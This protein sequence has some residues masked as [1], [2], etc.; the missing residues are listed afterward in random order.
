MSDPL[1]GCAYLTCAA[2]TATDERLLPV[3]LVVAA[4]TV[5]AVLAGLWLAR[6]LTSPV[7]SGRIGSG[8]DFGAC[9][10]HDWLRLDNGVFICLRCNH[11]AGSRLEPAGIRER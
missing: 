2:V 4:F 5:S 8:D 6:R 3:L 7:G 11:T 1:L 9:R 10:L